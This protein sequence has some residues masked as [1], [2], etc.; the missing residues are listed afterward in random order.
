[1][2]SRLDCWELLGPELI[3]MSADHTITDNYSFLKHAIPQRF[4][5]S[6]NQNTHLLKLVHLCIYTKLVFCFPHCVEDN[7]KKCI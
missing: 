1:M 5:K 4:L 6:M 3:S 7:K 2:F